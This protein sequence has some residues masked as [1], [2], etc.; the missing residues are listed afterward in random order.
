VYVTSIQGLGARRLAQFYR[1]RWRVEQVIDEL[2]NGH[3]LD[4]L[5]TTRLHP[6]RVAVGF[7]LLARNLAIGLQ[8]HEAQA[9]P[10][11]IREPVAFRAIHVEGLGLFYHERETLILA[12][13]VPAGARTW[14]LPWTRQF[15][16][17]VA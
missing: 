14:A 4:H 3:D 8:I 1:Q 5:V 15:V 11:V 2:V 17:L 9:R 13:L 6:N 16:R 10:A 7:R 12:P